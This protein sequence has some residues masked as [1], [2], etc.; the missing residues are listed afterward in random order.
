MTTPSGHDDDDRPRRGV[1]DSDSSSSSSSSVSSASSEDGEDSS[2]DDYDH[3]NFDAMDANSLSFRDGASGGLLKAQES[4]RRAHRKA[5][6]KVS[7]RGMVDGQGG[8]RRGESS[9]ER[10]SGEEDNEEA[11]RMS[12]KMAD[13]YITES[14]SITPGSSV[15]VGSLMGRSLGQ[16]M[17]SSFADDGLVWGAAGTGGG[18]GNGTPD[19]AYFHE[20]VSP[21]VSPPQAAASGIS[22]GSRSR[23]LEIGG[24]RSKRALF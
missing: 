23:P 6:K 12:R 4:R 18:G 13:T 21:S 3:R 8:G 22:G 7:K 10:S 20:N 11:S 15:A 19:D 2:D 16:A 24:I 14:M 1:E 5:E 9:E 17:S